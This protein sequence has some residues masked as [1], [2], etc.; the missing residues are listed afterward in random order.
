MD[1]KTSLG[2]FRNLLNSSWPTIL[3]FEEQYA[4]DAFDD[5]RINWLQANWE[6]TVEQS[7]LQ[8]HTFLQRYGEGAD[9]G[10][11]SSRVSF[12]D[13][14]PTHHIICRP[15]ADGIL[16][17]PFSDRPY[18]YSELDLVVFDRF[19]RMTEE[20]WYE[21]SP[22]FD[23]VLADCGDTQIIFKFEDAEFSLEKIAV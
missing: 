3:A 11:V 16:L 1:V 14:L 9:F 2:L 5:F 22:P 4:E 15:K 23:C 21:E 13:A 17:T 8:G 10:G 7:L 20:G 18:S 19:V 6:L 12:P